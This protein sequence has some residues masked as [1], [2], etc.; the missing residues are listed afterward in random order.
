MRYFCE[1]CLRDTK[2]KSKYSELKSKSHKEFENM[3]I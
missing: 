3:N 2:N 1:F